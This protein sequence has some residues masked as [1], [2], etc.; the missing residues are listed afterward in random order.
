VGTAGLLGG[1]HLELAHRA[2]ILVD[3]EF[4]FYG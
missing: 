4:M 3:K 1:L 2:L